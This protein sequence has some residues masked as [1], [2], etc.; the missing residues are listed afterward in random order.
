MHRPP[1]QHAI[2][3]VLQISCGQKRQQ[4][5]DCGIIRLTFSIC[6]DSLSPYATHAQV[7]ATDSQKEHN[8]GAAMLVTQFAGNQQQCPYNWHFRSVPLSLSKFPYLRRLYL[9]HTRCH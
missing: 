2:S 5:H 4:L 9:Q 6:N 7:Q 8:V 3:C 1:I